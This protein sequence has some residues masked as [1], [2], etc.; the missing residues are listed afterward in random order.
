[1]EVAPLEGTDPAQLFFDALPKS[2]TSSELGV[3]RGCSHNEKL[4]ALL[5]HIQEAEGHPETLVRGAL[6]GGVDQMVYVSA[7]IRVVVA[8]AADTDASS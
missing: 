1:M 5:K 6:A 8:A 2:L 4:E 7:D 3:H